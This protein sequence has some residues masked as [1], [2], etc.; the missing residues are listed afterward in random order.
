MTRRFPHDA[1][2]RTYRVFAG[3][4]AALGFALVGLLPTALLAQTA[5]APLIERFD[6]D[7]RAGRLEALPS[8]EAAIFSEPSCTAIQRA[9]ARRNAA[10]AH[11]AAA[12]AKT[13][14]E[15]RLPLLEAGERFG[16]P[17]QL[18]ASIADIRRERRE[19]GEASI[20][21]QAALADIA[22]P[23]A[24]PVPPA[25]ELVARF[26][27]LA[28]QE[29]AVAANFVRGDILITRS[30]RNVVIE[31]APVP[32]QFDYDSDRLTALGQQYADDLWRILDTQNRPQITVVGH[33]DPRGADAYNRSLSQRRAEAIRRLLIERGYPANSIRAEGKGEAEP[34]CIEGLAQYSQEQ[35]WQ[36][37]R[38]VEVRFGE[39][40]VTPVAG[41][42]CQ[43]PPRP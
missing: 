15:E 14:P 18:M 27:R 41:S 13:T 6:T 19:H 37:L 29:R 23:S 3:A 9:R 30:L 17:W 25:P 31:A 22:D 16:K 1:E 36:M 10:L 4:L 7:I 38:R 2:R 5:C 11:V 24:V 21:Y 43:V 34:L 12:N 39:G 20:A 33:T 8:L 35:V 26:M 32:V 42:T 40:P 28:G